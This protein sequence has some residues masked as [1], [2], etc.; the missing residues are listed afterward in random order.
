MRKVGSHSSRQCRPGDENVHPSSVKGVLGHDT[1]DGKGG[2]RQTRDL[3]S[4]VSEAR[5]YRVGTADAD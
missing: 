1:P 3:G 5:D 2:T 4:N